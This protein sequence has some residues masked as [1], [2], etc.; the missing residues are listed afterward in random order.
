MRC[1]D[2]GIVRVVQRRGL[3]HCTS[4]GDER[5]KG[6]RSCNDRHFFLSFSY[7]GDIVAPCEKKPA[8]R[9]SRNAV[10]ELQPPPI[11][12]VMGTR[13]SISALLSTPQA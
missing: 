10:M 8:T 3:V 1:D 4:G 13:S 5:E 11:I 12:D 6:K 9:V 7:I 2:E